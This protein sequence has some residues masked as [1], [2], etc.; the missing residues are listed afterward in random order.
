MNCYSDT[1]DSCEI[2]DETWQLLFDD[3]E[4]LAQRLG[5][6]DADQDVWRPCRCLRMEN[7]AT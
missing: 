4:L 7:I 6:T 3:D 5:S 1:V 2:Q